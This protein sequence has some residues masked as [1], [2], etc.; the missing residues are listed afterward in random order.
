MGLFLSISIRR[1]SEDLGRR[2]CENM[3]VMWA[4]RTGEEQELLLVSLTHMHCECLSTDLKSNYEHEGAFARGGSRRW[5]A[6]VY[7]GVYIMYVF[8]THQCPLANRETCD[9]LSVFPFIPV[10]LSVCLPLSLIPRLPVGTR[11]AS[12][13]SVAQ[14]SPL[15]KCKAADQSGLERQCTQWPLHET[16]LFFFCRHRP[17]SPRSHVPDRMR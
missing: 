7:V 6:H 15:K 11:V 10:S 16:P 12:L 4:D 9:L 13:A 1:E 8:Y 2:N 5:G 17:C 14:A 3:R